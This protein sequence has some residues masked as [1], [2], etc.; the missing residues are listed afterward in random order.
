MVG[1]LAVVAS[2][3]AVLDGDPGE[4]VGHLVATWSEPDLPEA[5]LTTVVPFGRPVVVD[6][7]LAASLDRL[8]GAGSAGAVTEGRRQGLFLM[9]LG[10][11]RCQGVQLYA[12][13]W[14]DQLWFQLPPE[15]ARV[16]CEW[17]PSTIEVWAVSAEDLPGP[18]AELELVTPQQR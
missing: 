11:D 4:R 9:A 14:Q 1:V 13:D 17:A 16:A 6:D 10:Y 12:D 3:C 8:A 5:R 15:S 2:G 7:R 18:V